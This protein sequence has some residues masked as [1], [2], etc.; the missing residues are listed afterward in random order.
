MSD[1]LL[2]QMM[3]LVP[4]LRAYALVLTRSASDA[5]DLVQ[6]TLLRAWRYREGFAEGTNLKAWLFRILR[7]RFLD[8]AAAAKHIV[9]DADGRYAA[10]LISNPDQEFSLRYAE[11]LRGLRLLSEDAREALLLT[12]GSG[13][14]YAE[15]ARLCGCPVG[16]MKS[17]VN[18]A[19]QFLADHLDEVP[20]SSDTAEARERV[21]IAEGESL[22]G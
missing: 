7:N 9:E 12:V 2:R 20:G 16:T 18:R 15:A 17:R 13:H 14:T 8:T 19:R 22:R 21:L 4:K 11:L 5:D 10:E 1:P 3:D 6:E